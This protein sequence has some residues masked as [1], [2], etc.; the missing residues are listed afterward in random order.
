MATI[1]VRGLDEI[2][3]ERLRLRAA[4]KNRSLEDEVRLILERAADDDLAVK[5]ATFLSGT[6]RYRSLTEG[7]E[8]TPADVLIRE[9]RESAHR[10]SF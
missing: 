1:N 5:R 10:D 8:H 9:D 2:V 6:E 7:R 3:I 4:L